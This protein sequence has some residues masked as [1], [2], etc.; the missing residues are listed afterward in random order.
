MRR[1]MALFCTTISPMLNT[2]PKSPWPI[3]SDV[4]RALVSLL[5]TNNVPLP[6]E[7]TMIRNL[8]SLEREE[9]H[10]LKT[11]LAEGT[12]WG[13]HRLQLPAAEDRLDAYRAILSPV[14]RIPTELLCEIFL[15]VLPEVELAGRP[16][17]SLKVTRRHDRQTFYI[18]P[19]RLGQVC[20][21]WR[22]TAVGYAALWTR[23]TLSRNPILIETQLY[24]SGNVPLDV[25]SGESQR[26]DPKS[27]A[28][29]VNQSSRWQSLCVRTR[30]PRF[31]EQ[32]QAVK[33][34]LPALRILDLARS[35]SLI[36]DLFLTAPRLREVSV[37][38]EP[39][40][41]SR[42]PVH[43]LQIPWS[44]ITCFR[45]SNHKQ[46]VGLAILNATHN[47]VECA[48]L[49]L[50]NC[51]IPDLLIPILAASPNL[52]A[53]TVVFHRTTKPVMVELLGAL[54]A[55][56]DAPPDVC[57]R[58]SRLVM[59]ELDPLA[60]SALLNVAASRRTPPITFLRAFYS[61][62]LTS[63]ALDILPRVWRP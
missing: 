42:V 28:L 62:E 12:G 11:E 35:H 36:Q 17:D 18:A 61:G 39:Y 1:V 47:L 5:S 52:T 16:S 55:S 25:D 32:I 22:A 3:A 6:G 63:G 14:R 43:Q 49:V 24:R 30:S 34:K 60:I 21:R 15:A 13:N 57:P 41:E 37:D 54:I 29:V 7:V 53:L 40:G 48:T 31:F 45:G 33:G 38:E 20:Q 27:L 58:L 59:G 23:I 44:Q 10:R 4:Q 9:I 56:S 46:D 2:H 8:V 50:T 19:W 51:S 26:F